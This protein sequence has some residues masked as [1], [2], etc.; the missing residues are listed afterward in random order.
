MSSSQAVFDRHVKPAADAYAK[1]AMGNRLARSTR[2]AIRAHARRPH[3]ELGLIITYVN[4]DA[5]SI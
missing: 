2:P 5:S 3:D 4:K 1:D